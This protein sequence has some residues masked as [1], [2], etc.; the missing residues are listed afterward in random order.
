MKQIVIISGKGGT[1]KT[2]ITAAFAAL[3]ENKII[4]DCDVDAPDLHLLL[5]PNIQEK[6]LF[7]SGVLAKI[8]PDKCIQCGQCKEQCRFDAINE[9]FMVDPISCEGCGFCYHLCPAKAITLQDRISGEWFIS[10]T[11]YGTF[12]H[13]ELGIAEANSGN[14]I[15]LLRKRAVAIAETRQ[16]EVV[17]IDGA[18]GISCPVI[19]CI[20]NT[21]CAIVVIEPTLSGLHD[22]DRVIKVAQHF[23]T[24]VKVIINKYDLNTAMS[25][26]IEQYCV[27]ENITV[28]GKIPFASCIVD[29]MRAGKTIIE[30][31]DKQLKTTIQ[32]IW[33]NIITDV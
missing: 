24:P 32:Q 10:E 7:Q 30:S 1:G 4:V 12:I 8:D 21:D 15:S 28:V 17:L 31:T 13:A 16:S 3:L 11:R 2:V 14:L 22:A 20:T 6:H 29:L 9:S 5:A 18:P 19:A 27:A 25:K 26:K 33:D 23:K